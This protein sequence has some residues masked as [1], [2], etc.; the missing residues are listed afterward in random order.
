LPP[1]SS[2]PQWLQLLQ[3]TGWHASCSQ[4]SRPRILRC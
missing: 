1:P 4:S 2:C 3:S